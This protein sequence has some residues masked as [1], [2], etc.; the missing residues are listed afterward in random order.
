MLVALCELLGFAR[1]Y[2]AVPKWNNKSLQYVK[3]VIELVNRHM[4]AKH[5][6]VHLL[7]IPPSLWKS[8][9]TIICALFYTIN[10]GSWAENHARRRHRRHGESDPNCLNLFCFTQALHTNKTAYPSRNTVALNSCFLPC[11]WQRASLRTI[12]C[13]HVCVEGG[14]G[15]IFPLYSGGDIFVFVSGVHMSLHWCIYVRV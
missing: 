3:G 4:E 9:F 2:A 10:I 6:W 7:V 12:P 13:C 11:C 15:G 14:R 8:N 1:I 5:L